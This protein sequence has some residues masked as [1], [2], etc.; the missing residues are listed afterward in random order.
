MS[1]NTD[2][3]YAI[4]AQV[5]EVKE[6]AKT[7]AGI[8]NMP[9]KRVYNLLTRNL[10]F[11]WLKMKATPEEAELIRQAR[12]PGIKVIPRAQ[13]FYPRGN[14][15]PRFW[16]LSALTTRAWRGWS[17]ITT[18]TCGCPGSQQAEFDS[19]GQSIPLGEWGYIPRPRTGRV[20]F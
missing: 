20:L 4:P 14:W 9:E 2:C 8:L 5:R 7:V 3:I 6:T 15:L 13:R 18:G 17:S 19:R 1:F 11:V 10:S 16:G 12:L